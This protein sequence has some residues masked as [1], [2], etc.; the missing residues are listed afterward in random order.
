MVWL[1]TAG[2]GAAGSIYYELRFTNLSSSPCTMHGYPGV[3]AIDLQG[4]ALGSPAARSSGNVKTKAV[5]LSAGATASATLRIVQA[6][7]FPEEKCGLRTAAGLRVY[8]PNDR[9]SRLVPFPFAACA[10]RA[11][12]F[13]E[14][15]PVRPGL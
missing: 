3:S 12:R 2:N 6:G 14:V 15:G 4:R 7:N 9:A 1:D 10:R 13:L 8:P 5:T 11:P